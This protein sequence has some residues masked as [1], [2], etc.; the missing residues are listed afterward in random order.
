MPTGH[1]C[2]IGS[3]PAGSSVALRLARRGI[4]VTVLESGPRYSQAEKQ[5]LFSD[6]V[7]SVNSEGNPYRLKEP[8]IEAFRNVGPV[9]L[10]LE[11]E[12]VRGLGGTSLHWLG[13][14][15]RLLRADFRMRSTFGLAQDWPI[16][17]DDL[18]PYYGQAE[19]EIGVAGTE[20][21]PF[22]EHRS[23]PYPMPALPFSY[24]DTFL[25]RTTDRLGIEFHHTP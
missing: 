2:V 15:P 4:S 9:S 22:A 14:T 7:Q 6:V 19:R 18:E 13:N 11:G 3:G 25:K 21:N 1:V 12:R 8:R 5:A 16:G 20:D 10:P 23:T 24:A 17:Y